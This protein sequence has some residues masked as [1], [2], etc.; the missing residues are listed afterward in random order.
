MLSLSLK[1]AQDALNSFSADVDVYNEQVKSGV[2]NPAL[3]ALDRI[4]CGLSVNTDF[5]INERIARE[6][7]KR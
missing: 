7:Q 2:H 3:I 1:S 4:M 5:Y 6:R